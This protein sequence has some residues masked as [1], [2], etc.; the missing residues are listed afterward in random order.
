MTSFTYG[1]GDRPLRSEETK[2][3][4]PAVREPEA[5]QL[6]KLQTFDRQAITAVYD[7]YQPTVYRY[8]YRRVGCVDTARDL[9]AEIFRRFLYAVSEGRG[10]DRNLR[11]WLFRS[12]HNLIIDHYRRQQYRD[13]LPLDKAVLV[14][15]EN[16]AQA[17]E[18]EILAGAVRVA[19]GKLSP[20]Q[21]EVVTLK[22]LEGL[23][24][25]E[26]AEIAGKSVGAVKSLQHRA[27]ASLRRHLLP[28][29]ER[30]NV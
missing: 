16:P 24:N 26:V 18:H 11:A 4:E 25:E 28:A 19:L 20:D 10:P 29:E 8:I 12:A 15:T 13:H 2:A 3:G 27:L 5:A 22:F 7:Q 30:A 1:I 14:S 6:P 23:T 21:Q 17:A 9:T